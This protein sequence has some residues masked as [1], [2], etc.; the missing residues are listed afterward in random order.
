VTS[1]AP[2]A[3]AAAYMATARDLLAEG[4]YASA[5]VMLDSLPWEDRNREEVTQL[6]NQVWRGLIGDSSRA[7]VDS[8]LLTIVLQDQTP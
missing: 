7:S 4:R 1:P 8:H 3:L 5:G 6:R 2:A